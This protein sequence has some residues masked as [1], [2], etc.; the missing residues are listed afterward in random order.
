MGRH[1]L[2]V[3]S[4][5]SCASAHGGDSLAL[6]SPRSLPAA[7]VCGR[8]H[9]WRLLRHL[10]IAGA[11][12]ASGCG[13]I[14][15]GG[16]GYEVTVYFPRAVSLFRSSQVRVLGLPA[17][18][19]TDIVVEGDRVR[20]D[21]R[22]DNDVPVPVDVRAALIPQSLIGE[23]YVQLTPAWVEGQDRLQDLPADERVIGLDEVII[24][25]EPDEALA[26][27]NEFLE[28]LNPDDL[29]RLITS[30]A[31]DLEGNGQ[32]LNRALETVSGL[33]GSFAERDDELAAIV[34]NFDEF[35]ATLVTRESQMGE[36]IDAFARTTAV[37]A[38][39]RQALEA[40]LN[41]LARISESGLNLVAEHATALRRDVDI[42]G[43]LTQSV[44][45]NLD[46]VTQLLDSGPL[47]AEG[48]SDAYN[49]TLRAINLRTQFGPI[50]QAALE[51]IL[52]AIFGDDVR[53]PCIPV[54][55]A[56]PTPLPIEGQSTS[57]AVDTDIA[58]V[59]TPVDDV[60]DLLGTPT[61]AR[62]GGGASTADRVADGAS[63]VGRLLRDAAESLTGGG[64]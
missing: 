43:R 20:V 19:V 32:N 51:P 31:E 6:A 10:G 35:T 3:R 22:V 18:E 52:Q 41:G 46:A 48:L 50:A 47:L 58:A 64:G 36:V 54:D 42:L 16:D 2:S 4:G 13:F 37:L 24:P 25:V 55:T 15:G 11:L 61:A 40:T 14:G 8:R 53:V 9:P 59:R 56:C 27:L 38:Q 60:L 33:V 57:T 62:P 28:Q 23:R 21:L 7:A 44:V 12:L 30:A 63:G 49:P 34:D 26:A 39:E 17:G 29:G 45:T 5:A 1:A